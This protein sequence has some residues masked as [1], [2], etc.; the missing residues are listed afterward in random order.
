MNGISDIEFEFVYALLVPLFFLICEKFCKYKPA[1]LYFPHLAVI[2]ASG[3]INEKIASI[4]KWLAIIFLSIALASPVL[5]DK[6]V[7]KSRVGYDI[8]VAIDASG[9]MSRPFLSDKRVSKFDI[10]KKIASEFIAKRE[11]DNLSAVGFGRYAFIISPLTYDKNALNMMVAQL[12]MHE[13]FSEGTAIGDAIAQGVRVLKDSEAKNKI[14]VLAT[15]GEEEGEVTLTYDKATALAK[16]HNIKIYTI[17]I[18]QKGEFNAMALKYIS[19]ETDGVFF[20]AN[21]KEALKSVYDKIDELE[22]S[23]ITTS[24]FVKKDYLYDYFLFVAFIA[25]GFY[26]YFKHGRKK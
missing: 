9:S 26:I 19:D 16:K 1:R 18:G 10:T 14:I 11:F 15:D 20:S 6:E 7:L 13:S 12:N 2:N 21:D 17:G 5:M 4:F 23:K 22:K 3:L 25:L 8:V 24:D